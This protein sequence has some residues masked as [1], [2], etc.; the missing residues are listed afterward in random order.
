VKSYLVVHEHCISCRS[1]DG[2]NFLHFLSVQFQSVCAHD[3]SR[4]LSDS[5]ELPGT[6]FNTKFEFFIRFSMFPL[7]PAP[8]MPV[9]T[10]KR[11]EVPIIESFGIQ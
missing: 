1:G 10:A 11:P 2:A 3:L 4:F 6:F 7:F 8:V 5:F 9:I